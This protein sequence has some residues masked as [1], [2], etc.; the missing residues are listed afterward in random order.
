MNEESTY[1]YR[2]KLNI[3]Q[4]E[5]SI[6]VKG[7]TFTYGFD[8]RSGL[9]GR[10][11]V[12]G[13]DFLSGM[14]SEIPDIYLSDA[15]DLRDSFYAAKYE[16]QAE[17]DIISANPYEV[18]IRT[19]GVYR[20]SSGEKFPVRYRITYEIQSDGTVFII[21][22]N[23]VYEPCV[24][25]W[26]C[27]SRGIL[28]PDLCKYYSYLQD[29]SIYDTIGDYTVENMPALGEKD[30]TLFNGRL[31]PWFWIGNDNT[32][33]ELCVWDVEHHRYGITR[34]SDKMVDPMGEIGANIS[35]TRE[36]KNPGGAAIRQQDHAEGG[37]R[38]EIFSI[39]NLQTPA[40]DVWEQ[41]DYFAL[42]VTPPKRYDP[43]CS[44]IRP[45][46]I[47]VEHYHENYEYP[48][49]EDIQ[50]Y[51]ENGFNTLIGAINWHP[52]EYIAEKP[53]EVKELIEE[54][55]KNNIKV[56]P[57]ISIMDLDMHTKAFQENG[58]DWRIEPIVEYEYDTG[59]MCPGSPGWREYWKK[60]IDHLVE[61]HD[62]DGVYIDFWYDKITCRNPRHG[63]Q[64]RYMRP[65]F[66][67]VREM[68]GYAN[69]KFREKNPDF[70]VIASTDIL[71]VSMICSWSDIRMIGKHNLNRNA[72]DLLEEKILYNSHRLGCG[73]II[74]PEGDEIDIRTISLSLLHMS[75]I[76]LTQENSAHDI[77]LVMKYWNIPLM[78]GTNKA[79]WYPA[80]SSKSSVVKS[81]DDNVL[82]NVHQRHDEHDE[83]LLTMINLSED[84]ASTQI[85]IDNPEVLKLLEN[86]YYSFY[87]PIL[88]EFLSGKDKHTIQ[89]LQSEEIT[90]SGFGTRFIY[91]KQY[92]DNFEFGN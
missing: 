82:V 39:R 86:E 23:K 66:P 84:E 30:V 43:D 79:D 50:T 20:N 15:R 63:C 45:F 14:N 65:T 60:Q 87:D 26:L 17:C 33:I 28:N 2:S 89:E 36:G 1:E 16:T 70:I 29:Q 76:V 31:I 55:H 12:M 7:E 38:W 51:R 54:C 81:S 35:C 49:K 91:L 5:K 56:I 6:L 22:H 25:R 57:R 74:I 61:N 44:A 24:I 11:E 9:I 47:P 85:I 48:S 37:I 71:P 92:S 21:V 19:H 34:I 10:L 32:G 72:A 75:P 68:I 69:A 41:I 78:F 42:S 46:Y 27:I 52:G 59:L 80:L 90:V 88:Q 62:F 53:D 77:E 58:P 13:D 83:L 3:F 4:D 40:K 64:K 18:H 8:K 67:W 73:S